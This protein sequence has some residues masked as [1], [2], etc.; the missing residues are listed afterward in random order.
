MQ[1]N[2]IIITLPLLFLACF[3]NAEAQ[4]TRTEKDLLGEKQIPF[5]AYYGVQTL[6]ALENFPISLDQFVPMTVWVE[7][8]LNIPSI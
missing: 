2:V 5:D 3:Q 6:R 4:K 8:D 1:K 7:K